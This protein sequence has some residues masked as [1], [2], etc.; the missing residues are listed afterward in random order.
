[1]IFLLYVLKFFKKRDIIQGG[2]LFKEIYLEFHGFVRDNILSNNF[3]E[4]KA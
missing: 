3:E 1:M 2:T 4:L